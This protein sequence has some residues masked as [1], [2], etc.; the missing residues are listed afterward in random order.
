ML[1]WR[2]LGMLFRPAGRLPWMHEFAQVPTSL[3]LPDRLR[4]YFSCRPQREA[5]GSC[6]SY[7]GFVDLDRSDP[8]TVLEVSPEPVLELGEAGCFDQFGVMAGSVVAVGDEFWLYYCGW[9]RRVAV[10]YDWAIGLAVSRDGG[11]SFSRRG[12]GP[13]VGPSL[14][15]P[16]L[17]ACPIVRRLGE[18]DWHMW[19]LSG[20][21]WLQVAGH[22][23]SVYVIMHASSSDGVHWARD[24]QPVIPARV[25]FECQTSASTFAWQGRQRMLFSYRHGVDFRNSERGY[26]IGHAVSDDLLR[27]QRDDDAA[28][29]APSAA[30]WDSQMIC[31]PHVFDLDGRTLMLYCGNEFGR[32][33]FGWAEL[34]A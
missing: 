14:D 5:D 16:Y 22:P 7:S 18:D 17:Q 1:H 33:G 21:T 31:Y 30:G 20:T 34:L 28:G 29:I 13:I 10:P 32:E 23:E 15:E 19:Y 26:R 4:V 9:S 25:D 12:R 8:Q 6:L 11:R 2:K 27:W 3:L 24:A